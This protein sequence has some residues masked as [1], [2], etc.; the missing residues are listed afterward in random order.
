MKE[1]VNGDAVRV[2]DSFNSFNFNIFF[3]FHQINQHFY[4]RCW[5]D[6]M[7]IWYTYT[8]LFVEMYFFISTDS[9]SCF[10]NNMS[11]KV[12]YLTETIH[13]KKFAKYILKNISTGSTLLL[14]R[15]CIAQKWQYSLQFQHIK[16][17]PVFR[18]ILWKMANDRT[19]CV[20]T[21]LSTHTHTYEQLNWYTCALVIR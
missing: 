3:H 17:N 6:R 9:W 10:D 18:A 4:F 19:F 13:W 21:W 1:I 12:F 7:I 16:V 2:I 11:T 15:I 5:R 8:K 20:L 14:C